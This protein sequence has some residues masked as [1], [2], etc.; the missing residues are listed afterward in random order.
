MSKYVI[1]VYQYLLIYSEDLKAT[2][3]EIS[4]KTPNR[5]FYDP[6]LAHNGRGG[7]A[8]KLIGCLESP[9]RLNTF[10]SYKSY[11]NNMKYYYFWI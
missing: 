9:I 10:Q 8:V 3:K 7:L 1:L 6:S 11:N 2:I 5:P 4:G